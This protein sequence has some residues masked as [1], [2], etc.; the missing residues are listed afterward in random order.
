MFNWIVYTLYHHLRIIILATLV[1]IYQNNHLT[2][3]QWI[4]TQSWLK[5]RNKEANKWPSFDLLYV[6][7]NCSAALRAREQTHWWC[8]AL[9]GSD[10]QTFINQ[11][12]PSS[13]NPEP[14][15]ADVTALGSKKWKN[16][17][18]WIFSSIYKPKSILL[19]L[20]R[21][22]LVLYT[23][24]LQQTSLINYVDELINTDLTSQY[25]KRQPVQLMH[26]I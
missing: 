17:L 26:Y 14:D 3:V 10:S 20:M 21:L 11:K 9:L 4:K 16:R 18:V 2:D 19:F 15:S 13:D 8:Q 7:Y 25:T 22:H 1:F 12:Y 24:N 5:Q 23:H 6:W